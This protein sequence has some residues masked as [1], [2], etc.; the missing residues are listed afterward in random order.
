M[1]HKEWFE[2]I[3]G[4]MKAAVDQ[5]SET[6]ACMLPD[7]NGGPPVCVEMDQATCTNLGGTFLGGPC[8]F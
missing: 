4:S 6:G 3:E 8:G 2:R 5:G 1:T 7:S